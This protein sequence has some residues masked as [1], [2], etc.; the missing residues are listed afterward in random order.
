M[1]ALGD[2]VRTLPSL[3]ALRRAY[4]DAQISWLVERAAADVVRGRPEI[5]EVIEFPRERLSELLRERRFLAF[6]RACREVGQDLRDRRFDLVL[7][8]HAILKSG[9]LSWATRAPRR[10]S[11][12]RPFSRESSFWF[13][14]DRARLSPVKLSRYDRN[15]GL[16]EYLAVPTMDSGTRSLAG[17][18]AV[19]P[20]QREAVQRAIEGGGQFALIHPGSSPGAV[21]KRYRAS[22]YAA[23]ASELKRRRG[24]FTLVVRG[25]GE[26]EEQIAQDIVDVSRGA[27]RLAPACDELTDLIALIARARLFVGGDSGPLHMATGVGT[28]AIQL[29]GPTDPVEN[30]PR[31]AS[32]YRQLRV[33]V[34]CSPCRRGCAAATC[35]SLLP[36]E[37]IVDAACELLDETRAGARPRRTPEAMAPQWVA[38]S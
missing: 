15:A 24:V 35:M 12:A 19:S 2:V 1:G 4:P 18:M 25:K 20:T 3:Q 26:A 6:A 5:D 36:H 9:L 23:F 8:F 32:A 10:V 22:G 11:Y 7:D 16:V 13:A 14:T 30:E 29:I 33:D 38:V 17:V 37:W 27:A 34:H 21:H 28:P 31:G